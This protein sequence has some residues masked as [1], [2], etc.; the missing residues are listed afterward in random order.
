MLIK[1]PKFSVSKHKRAIAT[2]F[3]LLMESRLV[4]AREMNLLAH[5]I[6][7]LV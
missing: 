6:K 4:Y 2:I 3:G 1:T 7:P 5:K